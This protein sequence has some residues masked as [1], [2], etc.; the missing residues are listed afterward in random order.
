[1]IKII[2]GNLFDTDAKIICH[3]VNCQGVMGSGV[4][5]QVK[6]KFS[7]VFDKYKIMCNSTKNKSELLGNILPVSENKNIEYCGSIDDNGRTIVNLF[8]QERYGY[9]GKCYTSYKDLRKCLEKVY[10]M[11]WQ[12]NNHFNSK[13]AMPYLMGCHRGGGDWDKVYK[14]IDDIFKDRLV[15]LYKYKGE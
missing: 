7:H 8:A 1:M 10:E 4:A 11:T 2:E 12:K 3:Q 6:D 14:M 13:I 15:L 5:K 9:G